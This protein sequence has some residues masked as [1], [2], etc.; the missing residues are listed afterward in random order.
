MLFILPIIAVFLGSFLA[1]FTKKELKKGRK[2]LVFTMI[3]L[4][5]YLIFYSFKTQV[6]I[7]NLIILGIPVLLG[8]FLSPSYFSSEKRFFKGFFQGIPKG[9]LLPFYTNSLNFLFPL[10]LY[11]ILEGSLF[12]RGE[13][14]EDLRFVSFSQAMFL[15]G[16]LISSFLKLEV[17]IP[18]STGFFIL[19]LSRDLFPSFMEEFR[20]ELRMLGKKLF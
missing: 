8:F 11:S 15:I 12:F 6:N 2:Y 16:Y 9:L 19:I 17:F 18:L 7:L 10:I 1:F 14:K 20:A 5:T 3:G 4:L 13:L